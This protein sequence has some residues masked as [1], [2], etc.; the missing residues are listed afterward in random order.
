[1]VIEQGLVAL[2]AGVKRRR[3]QTLKM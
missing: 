3:V 2:P 1:V